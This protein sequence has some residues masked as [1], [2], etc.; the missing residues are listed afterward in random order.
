MA[1]TAVYGT[2][3][4]FGRAPA[5]FTEALSLPMQQPT[6]FELIVDLKTAKGARVGKLRRR[7]LPVPM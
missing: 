1:A 5:K 2:S 7:C 6:K 3:P 4:L